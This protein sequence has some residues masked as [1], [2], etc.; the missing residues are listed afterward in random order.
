M[1]KK[2]S[3]PKDKTGKA[4]KKATA[5]ATAA[6]EV[7]KQQALETQAKSLAAAKESIGRIATA[8]GKTAGEYA[9]EAEQQYTSIVPRVR[10]E[11]EQKLAAFNPEEQ[12]RPYSEIAQA[13][14]RESADVLG[15][16]VA[17]DVER[18]GGMI[19]EGTTA[20]GQQLSRFSRQAAR[21]QAQA[22]RTFE[23]SARG[24][25][26]LGSQTAFAMTRGLSNL[27][28]PEYQQLMEGVRSGEST[29]RS[30]LLDEI[31]AKSLYNV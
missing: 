7:A 27:Y 5:A 14:I 24:A 18:F 8:T 16:R 1:A 4:I 12:L 23:E 10:Q 28:N 20:A 3:A 9:Q 11:F 30:S 22:F 26:E 31:R 2:Q 29:R 6:A 19:A 25:T 17:G 21:Q 15:E 13:G